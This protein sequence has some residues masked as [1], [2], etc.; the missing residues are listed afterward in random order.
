MLDFERGAVEQVDV[1]RVVFEEALE[2]EEGLLA[3]H[4]ALLGGGPA[5]P[6]LGGE[7]GLRAHDVCS[8]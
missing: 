5:E 8:R 1:V 7:S 2:V 4:V 3:A 6:R